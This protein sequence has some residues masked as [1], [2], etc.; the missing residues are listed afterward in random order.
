[1]RYFFTEDVSPDN[2]SIIDLQTRAVWIALALILQSLIV[3][4]QTLNVIALN[5]NMP[6]VEF[7]GAMLQFALLLGSFFAMWM[8]F[9]PRSIRKQSQHS[10]QHPAG[11]QRTVLALTLIPTIIGA[12][13]GA[14]VVVMCFLP[15]WFANDGTALDMNAA[16]LLVQGRN[17]YTDSSML[18]VARQFDLPP[19]GTTPLRVGQFAGRLDYPSIADFQSTFDTALKSGQTPEFESKVSYPALSFLTLVP[20]AYLD[21]Y[22]VLP[23]YLLSYL[24]IVAVAW[25]GTRPELRPWV[26]LLALA[27]VPMWSSTFGGNLDIFYVLLIIL[28]WLQR[29]NRWNSALFLG[30]A[31]ASKQIAWLFIPFYFMMTWRNISFKEATCRIAIAGGIG[32]A[33]NL[34]FI[35]WNPQ[36]WLD[37]I[38]APIADPMF[39]LGIG[40]INLSITHLLPY[41]PGWVYE[42]LE[43]GAMIGSLAYYWRLCRR[44]P[45]AAMLLA[46][47]PLFF[48]WRSLPSYFS[49]TAFPIFMLLTTKMKPGMR[50]AVVPARRFMPAFGNARILVTSLLATF[51]GTRL[52]GEPVSFQSTRSQFAEQQSLMKYREGTFRSSAGQRPLPALP[53][54]L[55]GQT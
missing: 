15:P 50:P 12:I 9:R 25:K 10:K 42:V 41:F 37:G 53:L 31:V 47:I 23:L 21:H 3:L 27:N 32:L 13:I 2:R 8:A 34:P 19:A 48:A 46:V 36:A 29:N 45:E 49:C 5:P 4:Q 44:R 26:L 7:F 40:I 20:F 33:I 35:L 28:A 6:F 52:I 43:G 17:P 38:L 24:L 55:H 54:P 11:W 18:D 16:K 14:S 39:P 22:N 30:L 51:Q 1:M